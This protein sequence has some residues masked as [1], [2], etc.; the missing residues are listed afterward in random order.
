MDI[1]ERLAALSRVR[2]QLS[3]ARKELEPLHLPAN[4][5]LAAQA[6]VAAA[7]A[8]ID[9]ATAILRTPQ[10]SSRFVSPVL[11]PAFDVR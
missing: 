4:L 2:E 1:S 10:R 7:I 8:K 6:D 3:R 11:Q 5:D 9:R